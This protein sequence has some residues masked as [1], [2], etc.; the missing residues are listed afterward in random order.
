MD[1]LKLLNIPNY[2]SSYYL[3]GL[4]KTGQIQYQPNEEFRK[5]NG[6]PLLILR[7]GK[8]IVVIDNRDPVG[9]QQ[10]LYDEAA[11]YYT[12]NKLKEKPDYNKP[13]VKALFPHYPVNSWWLYS[14]L[15]GFDWYRECG[16]ENVLRDISAHTKRPPYRQNKNTYEFF[17]YVFF[18]FSLEKGGFGEPTESRFYKYLS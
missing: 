9:L 10:D 11:I 15:F 4:Y 18:R 7:A 1:A 12:T 5:W 16:F 17:N 13:K 6:T 2:I 14:K 8:K 3:L